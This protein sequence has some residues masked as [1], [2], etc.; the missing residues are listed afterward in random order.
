MQSL[1]Q[2][3]CAPVFPLSPCD[4]ILT[5]FVGDLTH[6]NFEVK[7]KLG[8]SNYGLN[9]KHIDCQYIVYTTSQVAQYFVHFLLTS[10]NSQE[11]TLMCCTAMNLN[12]Y[13]MDIHNAAAQQ[14]SMNG[15]QLHKLITHKQSCDHSKYSAAKFIYPKWQRNWAHR[16]KKTCTC[17]A[18]VIFSPLRLSLPVTPRKSQLC[19]SEPVLIC[20]GA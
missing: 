3:L 14:K 19:S 9:G 6:C 4:S 7:I 13:Q 5:Q 16:L 18:L 17:I 1:H 20:W 8:V 10:K 12:Q 15:C 2:L 11:E